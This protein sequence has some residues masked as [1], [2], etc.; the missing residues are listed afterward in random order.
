MLPHSEVNVGGHQVAARRWARLGVPSAPCARKVA[1]VWL[2][3]EVGRRACRVRG[4]K[5]IGFKILTSRKQYL[6]VAPTEL[7]VWSG[8]PTKLG[9]F[10]GG[11][12]RTGSLY[13]RPRQN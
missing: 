11:P 2:V 10:G 3:R 12:D 7:G 1:H 9:V 5:N 8:A 6:V 4:C 13:Q